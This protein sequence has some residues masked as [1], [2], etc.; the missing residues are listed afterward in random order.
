MDWKPTDSARLHIAYTAVG[1][2]F[3]FQIPV[4][5]RTIADAYQVVDVAASYEFLQGLTGFLRID[6]LL[7]RDYQEFVGFPNPGFYIRAGIALDLGL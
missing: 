5:D 2:R 4:P 3:D 1:D 6:N 7:D